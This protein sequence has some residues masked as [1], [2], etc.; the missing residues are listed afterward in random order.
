MAKNMFPM[1]T[2]SGAASK[3]IGTLIALALLALAVKDPVTAATWAKSATRLIGECI[4]G[5]GI[6]LNHVLG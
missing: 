4:D 2:G 1:R 3:V 6:F 5:L